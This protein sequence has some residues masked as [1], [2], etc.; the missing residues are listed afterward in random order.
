MLK[1][2]RRMKIKADDKDV[3]EFIRSHPLFLRNGKFDP[4]IYGYI[5]RNNLSMDPRTFEEIVRENILM[6]KLGAQLTKDIKVSDD[7]LL[8]YYRADRCKFKVSYALLSDMA[9]AKDADDAYKK[10]S[11]ILK[12]NGN[13]FEGACSQTGLKPQETV[14]F[15]KSDYL[16]GL[17][18][19][20]PVAATAGGMAKDAVSGPVSTRKGVII[21]KLIAIEGFDEA[22]FGVSKDDYSTRVLELKKNLA[23]EEWLRG[24][25]K[26]NALN[27]DPGEY[28]KYYR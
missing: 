10:I 13:N 22:G 6:Q 9:G 5:L 20:M 24:L 14:V 25:E 16:E 17:G 27:I 15:S 8:S 21:F 7:E 11:G 2:A 18:E 4:Q 28:E 3:I 1:E 26:A 19:A 23:L 12:A